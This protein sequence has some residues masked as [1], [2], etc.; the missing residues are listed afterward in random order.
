[1]YGILALIIIFACA[2][3]IVMFGLIPGLRNTTYLRSIPAF[4]RLR[5]ALGESVEKGTRLHVSLGKSS[6]IQSTNTSALVGL[7]ALEHVSLYSGTSDRP[8][9]VSSGDG[10]LALL[11]Q[12]A[13]RAAYRISDALES[14]NPDRAMMTGPTPFSYIAGALPLTDIENISAHILL[15]NFGPEVVLLTESGEMLS[16]YTFAGSDSLPAQ[17]ALYASAQ[18]PLLGEE[19][20]AVPAYLECGRLHIASLMVQDILRWTVIVTLAA[21]AVLK[22]AGIL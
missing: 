21:G 11:S 7:T 12:D 2:G 22:L 19:L 5:R 8:P 14:Y 4:E 3:L 20:Y 15:G 9:I 6:L 1:M 13:Q 10:G 16:A 17:A 18:E